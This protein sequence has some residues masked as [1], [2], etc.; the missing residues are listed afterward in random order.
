MKNYKML[1]LLITSSLFSLSTFSAH[2]EEST[3]LA[4]GDVQLP[5][6]THSAGFNQMKQ[7]L[8][9]WEGKLTQYTG[10]VVDVSSEFKLVSGGNL[11][12]EKLIEDGVEMLTTY[13]DNKDGELV[14]KH[15]CSLGTQPVF[16]VT[17]VSDDIVAVTLNDSEGGYHPKHHSYVNSMRW[18]VDADN[19]NLAVVDSTLYLN[20]DL[21]EQQTVIRRV[22]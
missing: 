12:T 3:V 17:E 1:F 5:E 21:V 15:Y 18:N 11:I 22:N 20:G 10:A 9:I 14:V 4:I 7:M 13:S 19:D 2:H 6:V 16:K 8:G